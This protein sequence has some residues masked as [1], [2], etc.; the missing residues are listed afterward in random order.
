MEAEEWEG[1]RKKKVKVRQ[2]GTWLERKKWQKN[3]YK[4]PLFILIILFGLLVGSLF[5]DA[6]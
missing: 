5:Y 3:K 1:I 2:I 6:F 4:T